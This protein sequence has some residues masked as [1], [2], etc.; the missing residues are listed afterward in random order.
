MNFYSWFQ[1]ICLPHKYFTL[2][3]NM[4]ASTEINMYF[5]IIVTN[6]SI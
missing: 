4:E 2:K 3:V 5:P 1:A 6:D